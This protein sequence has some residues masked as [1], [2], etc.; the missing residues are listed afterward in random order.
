MP[1]KILDPPTPP[2][3]GASSLGLSPAVLAKRDAFTPEIW[4]PKPDPLRVTFDPWCDPYNPKAIIYNDVAKAYNYIKGKIPATPLVKTKRS[5]LFDMGVYFKLETVHKTGSFHA[6]SA[7][8]ALHML[9]KEERANGVVT[10]SLGNWGM[11]LANEAHRVGIPAT[12]VLPVTTKNDVVEK[13]KDYGANVLTMGKN[14][15]EAKKIAIDWVNDIGTGTFINGYDHP[16]VIAGSGS[17]G[18]EIVDQLPTTDVILVP[19]GGGGLIAGIAV[20][21]KQLKPDVMIYGIESDKSCSFLKAL[22]NEKPYKV[23][24]PLDVAHSLA[25]PTAG[26]N[27]FH[28]ARSLIDKM[29]LVRDDWVTRAILQLA[30]EEQFIAEG[31]GAV[32][33]A[34]ILSEPNVVPELRDKNVVCIVSGGNIDNITFSRALE[35]AK[36][37]EGRLITA[38]VKYTA[39][40]KSAC[41]KVLRVLANLKCNVITLLWDDKWMEECEIAKTHI[42]VMFETSSFKHACRVKHVMESLFAGECEFTQECFQS[43]SICPCYPKLWPEL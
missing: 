10:A 3:C 19:I 33:L 18:I 5:D 42:L 38:K 41:Y 8:Y 14:L 35:R 34:A 26:Y 24:C 25:T 15:E 4:C 39:Q 12:I 9:S 37:I 32:A 16:H 21:V 30:E 31:A 11:A 17:I 29:V 13:C 40:D 1:K 20:A 43:Q 28:T 2:D 27:A 36:R 22:D 6:R 23:D 7:V